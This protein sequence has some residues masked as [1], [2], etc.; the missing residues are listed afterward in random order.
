MP[1]KRETYELRAFESER[2]FL[3]KKKNGSNIKDTSANIYT[4]MLL[5]TAWHNLSSKQKELYLYC[6]AQYFGES[7]SAEEHKT[8]N[9]TVKGEN[10]NLSLR[11][12]MNK[13]K[14]CEIYHIYTENTKRYFYSDMK[15][16]IQNG[17]VRAVERGKDTF[18]KNIYEFS[19]KWR[20]QGVYLKQTTQPRK[21]VTTSEGRNCTHK[22]NHSRSRYA[23]SRQW[24]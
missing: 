20:E 21:A 14:W 9:E 11:F 8:Y 16:L 12:T 22:Q 7:K 13:S 24:R 23:R 19:D 18:T 3:P 1:K 17:F 2:T 10:A 6:K 15:A 5:S 4:S